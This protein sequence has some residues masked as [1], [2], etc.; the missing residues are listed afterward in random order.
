[1]WCLVACERRREGL[2][3]EVVSACCFYP[4]LCSF[5]FLFLYGYSLL[6]SSSPVLWRGCLVCSGG[7]RLCLFR[8]FVPDLLSEQVRRLVVEFFAVLEREAASARGVAGAAR[9]GDEVE[10]DVRND[11]GVSLVG[12]DVHVGLFH[13]ATERA[14]QARH[15]PS[16]MG[17]QV[18]GKMRYALVMSF[19]NQEGV[20]GANRVD[21]K[22]GDTAVI[23]VDLSCGFLVGDDGAKD[24]VVVPVS[25]ELPLLYS[26]S[27]RSRC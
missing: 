1:M 12:D 15:N 3:L 6:Q 13:R 9:C 25:S 10:M 27:R 16:E 14:T 26:L 18:I 7:A 11:L 22:E 8:E 20:T 2:P 5:S 17:R 19:R 21:V 24:A 23:L 4:I